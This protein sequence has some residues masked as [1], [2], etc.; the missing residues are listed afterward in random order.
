MDYQ[1]NGLENSDD[2]IS[3]GDSFSVS[4]C[5]NQ[6]TKFNSGDKILIK[7]Y[8]KNSILGNTSLIIGPR[9]SGKTTLINDM[10]IGIQNEVKEIHYISPSAHLENLPYKS[11]K[12]IE[13][14]DFKNYLEHISYKRNEYGEKYNTILIL[15]NCMTN[16]SIFEN[17]SICELI[18]NGKCYNI[19][20][21]ISITFPSGIA[22]EIRVNFNNIFLFSENNK[23]N[24]KRLW[25]HYGGIFSSFITFKEIFSNLTKKFG[26]MVIENRVVD[27]DITDLIFFYKVYNYNIGLLDVNKFMKFEKPKE[28]VN[29][30]SII[31]KVNFMIEKRN[32]KIIELQKIIDDEKKIIEKLENIKNDLTILDI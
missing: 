11:Y 1:D 31:T 25:D 15:D 26:V 16:K 13:E 19:T 7:E 14:F 8:N 28:I 2:F 5:T 22:P 23:T 3:S 10:I 4:Q 9:N 17:K 12:S 32:N 6:N 20:L 21:I 24:I 30:N 27:K 18:F 29:I